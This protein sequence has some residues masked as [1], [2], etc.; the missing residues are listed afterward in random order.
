MTILERRDMMV[1][2]TGA[3]GFFTK[4]DIAG[5]NAKMQD[6]KIIEA[7]T[8]FGTKLFAV[9]PC[10]HA[11]YVCMSSF[12]FLTWSEFDMFLHPLKF[13]HLRSTQSKFA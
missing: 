8:T 4:E 13:D 5:G 2:E 3:E 11:R 6:F 7:V 1:Y 9:F 12:D 10:G